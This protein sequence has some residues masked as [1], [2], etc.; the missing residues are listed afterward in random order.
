MLVKFSENRKLMLFSS[1][2]LL[3]VALFSF[4]CKKKMTDVFTPQPT[5]NR[6]FYKPNDFVMGVDLSYVNQLEDNNVRFRDSSKAKDVFV[7]LRDRGANLVRVR[8]WHNPSWSARLNSAGKVYSNLSDVVR[9]IKRAKEAGMQVNLDL[10][11]SDEWADPAKQITPEAWKNLP[12]PA[13]KDSVY[14]YTL[15]VL[16]HLKA[17]NLTPEMVQIGNENNAGILAPLGSITNNNYQPFGDL[18]K[19]GIKAVRDFST[20]SAIKPQII[21][22]VAQLQNADWWANGVI[23]RAQVTDFDVLGVSHYYQWATVKTMAEIGASVKNLK[24]KYGKKIMVVELAY[25]WTTENGDGYGNIMSNQAAM[26]DYPMTPQ[27]QLKYLQDFTQA[28]V[29]NGGTG[30]MYW[31]PAWVPSTMR[32]L[33]GQGSS[34]DNNTLFDF[35]GNTLQ[36]AD[37]MTTRYKF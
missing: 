1:A 17:L 18:L 6:V 33:W 16:N 4:G 32:D 27:G 7:L 10:H 11:Y 3:S 8:L 20:N 2:F 13:L 31:E 35:T 15:S 5:D 21:L 19:A 9:T 24:A 36:G 14:S 37:F 26:P 28:L 30:V 23:N 22:H 29:S 12:F 34:W 25:S